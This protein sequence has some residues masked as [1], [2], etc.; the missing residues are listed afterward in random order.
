MRKVLNVAFN[1]AEEIKIGK[2]WLYVDMH[3]CLKKTFSVIESLI[4]K[5][6]YVIAILLLF[7]GHF[8]LL[9]K[10]NAVVFSPQF[11]F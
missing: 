9:G 5:I 2:F 6:N 10:T 3:G 7:G 11:L 1:A 4:I 8:F